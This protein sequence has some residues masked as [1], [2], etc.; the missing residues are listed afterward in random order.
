MANMLNKA[1][2]YHFIREFLWLSVTVLVVYAIMYPITSKMDYIYWKIN[3]FF[4]FVTLTYFRYSVTFKSLEFLRPSWVRFVL[5]ALNLSLFI[6]I[7][8]YEQKLISLA[9]NFYIEDFGFPKVFIDDTMK[10]ELFKYL[11]TEIVLFSTGS[12]VTL[13]AF[14]IRLIISYW[15]YYKHQANMLLED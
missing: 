5:F 13:S 1:T 8:N 4:I 2:P 3:A 6:F 7:A 9:D 11:Y 15:Q 12:L 14:Q 10:R